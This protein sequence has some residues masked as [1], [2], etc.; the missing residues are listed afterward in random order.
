MSFRSQRT[1]LA[2]R[3]AQQHSPVVGPERAPRAVRRE[4]PKRMTLSG[5]REILAFLG[6]GGS[7]GHAAGRY[8]L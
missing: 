4:R 2:G 8:H 5:A 1:A 3:S 7:E 6:A